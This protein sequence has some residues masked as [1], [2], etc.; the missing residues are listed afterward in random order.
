MADD[1]KTQKHRNWLQ[2]VQEQSW[3]PEILIS[4]IVLFALFQIPP[5]IKEANAFLDV[6]SVLIFSNGNVDETLAALLLAATYWLIIGFSTHLV[7]RSIWAAFVGLSYVY[8]DGVK[9]EKLKYPEK[10]KRVIRKTSDY[11]DLIIK[12]EKFCS[13]IFAA[14][15][16]IFM[17]TVGIFFFLGWLGV[18]F[19]LIHELGG[20]LPIIGNYIDIGLQVISLICVIDFI[21]LGLIKRIPYVNKI[22]YPF[23][24]VMSFLTLSPL[25]RS[26]YYGFV[27]N[28]K[29]WQV[30]IAM[31]VFTF[32][33]FF[34]VAAIRDEANFFDT[35]ELTIEYGERFMAPLNYYNLAEGK[36]S[37]RMLIESDIIDRNVAKIL[38][39][40]GSEHEQQ[41]ILKNCNYEEALEKEDLDY[42]SLLFS[43][44]ENFILLQLDGEYIYPEYLYTV[45][46]TLNRRGLTTYLDLSQHERGMH[47]LKLFYI[48]ES[49]DRIDTNNVA[50]IEFFKDAL[51]IVASEENAILSD[52]SDISLE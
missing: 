21:G 37:K 29:W 46:R 10:F 40:H 18:V 34:M 14:S 47:N 35:T 1:L 30:A 22:Y 39:V 3:E 5:L 31:F 7:G 36:P 11:K 20:D 4:G 9:I 44:L 38:I 12:L 19:L 32:G 13:T 8:I 25:Y 6:N 24:K 23:Y 15:F 17:C 43:C 33:T 27:T 49:E 26:I 50:D 41:Y 45:D 16:L 42:D 28:H 2:R 52:S 48:M 51:P